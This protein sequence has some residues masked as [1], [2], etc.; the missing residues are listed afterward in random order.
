MCILLHDS[1][2][3]FESI[4]LTLTWKKVDESH[5]RRIGNALDSAIKFHEGLCSSHCCH[6]TACRMR[7]GSS[8]DGGRW[9]T[10]DMETPRWEDNCKSWSPFDPYHGERRIFKICSLSGKFVHVFMVFPFLLLPLL[11]F[12]GDSM[13]Y[14][15]GMQ[16]STKDMDND[17]ERS[18]NCA[19]KYHG[20]WWY[21]NCHQVSLSGASVYYDTF[22]HSTVV[23][24]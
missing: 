13:A 7:F 17:L 16:F 22:F 21:K 9:E 12:L 3:W 20:G 24:F 23:K 2:D 19:H 11:W 4:F 1:Y 18:V 15:N 8:T 10:N 5:K 14:H 6:R